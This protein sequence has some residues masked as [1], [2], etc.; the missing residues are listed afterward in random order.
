VPPGEK[1]NQHPLDH[2]VLTHD[3]LVD[4]VKNRI[5]KSALALN[6]FVN[7]TDVSLGPLG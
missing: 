2:H 1:P 4:L 7:G 5:D 6:H 3:D